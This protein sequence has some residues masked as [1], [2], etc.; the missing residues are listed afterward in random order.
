M[1]RVTQTE[2]RTAARIGDTPVS[3]DE[4][5]AR[6]IPMMASDSDLCKRFGLTQE[7]LERWRPLIDAGRSAA[8]IARRYAC[9]R[10]KKVLRGVSPSEAPAGV[11][12]GE[13]DEE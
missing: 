13:K 9:A 3:E 2:I 12:G 7:Q 5:S 10:D 8:V 1:P 4:V 11:G 6:G